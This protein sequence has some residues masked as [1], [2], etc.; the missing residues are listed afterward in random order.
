VN[1]PIPAALAVLILTGCGSGYHIR[2]DPNRKIETVAEPS[3]TMTMESAPEESVPVSPTVE[4]RVSISGETLRSI[5]KD[6]FG[7]QLYW[8]H[9]MEWNKIPRGPDDPLA[10]GTAVVIPAEVRVMA[11]AKAYEPP[12]A[13]VQP[14]RP[15]RAR[16]RP[17]PEVFQV[18][19]TLSFDV[20]WYAVTAGH[21]T[22]TVTSRESF[23]GGPICYRFVAKAKSGLVFFFKVEDWLES[24]SL[25]DTLLPVQ[26]EKHLR[27][28]RYKKDQVTVF[29]RERG[30]AVQ[31]TVEAKLES[32]ARDLL[33]AFYH[34]RT[35]PLPVPGKDLVVKV[36]ADRDNYD[37]VVNVLRH[38]SVKV[39]AGE[40][41]TVVI[42][43]RLKSEGL[44]KQ[45]GD[46]L[47]WLTD[48]ARRMPVLVTSKVFLLGSVNIMLTKVEN[49]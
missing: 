35:L 45:K 13:A 16:G 34:A 36:H 7:N 42:K 38:E 10:P 20:K 8:R 33:G 5:S 11:G 48:D 25:A 44:W 39:P 37:L 19:E 31:G 2:K 41:R 9:L 49:K 15:Q 46:I 21:A 23:K 6:S 24:W 28:G 47:I 22:L 29:D 1:G 17:P 4:T 18:G 40:F 27:E 43:P 30:M 3:A 14:R 12:P 26:F 32:D